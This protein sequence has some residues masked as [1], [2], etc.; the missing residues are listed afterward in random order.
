MFFSAD[1]YIYLIL[2]VHTKRRN[3]LSHKKMSEL[4]YV[5]CNLRLTNKSKP[6]R[7]APV[8]DIEDHDSNDEWIRD[9]SYDTSLRWIGFHSLNEDEDA[10][11]CV[12]EGDNVEG[13]TPVEANDNLEIQFDNDS[14]SEDIEDDE[15]GLS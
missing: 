1:F 14:D 15:V 6:K 12:F 11:N 9:E 3:R 4:V 7:E 10:E 8:F 5:M 13:S 2:Q